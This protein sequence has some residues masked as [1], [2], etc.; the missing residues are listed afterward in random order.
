MDRTLY[1]NEKRGLEVTRDGPS[2][3]VR[4]DGLAGKRIPARLIGHV[5]IVGNVKL[6]AGVITLFTDN[7]VPVTF[8]NKK[9]DEIALTIPYNHQYN[10]HYHDQRQI[11][12]RET[13]I[14]YYKQWLASERRKIQLKVVK[15]LSRSVASVFIK[16]GFK[17]QDYQDFIIRNIKIGDKKKKNM[18]ANVIGNLTREMI[19]AGIFSAGFDPHIGIINRRENFGMVMDIFY[20]I[21]PE[22][23]L[24]TIQ[25]F[26]S[27]SDK[28][29][30]YMSSTGLAISKDGM[31]D[32]AQRF[33]NKKRLVNEFIENILD[34]LFETIRN[35]KILRQH[36]CREV[37]T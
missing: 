19:L 15:K 25:F 1:I 10:A 23:D 18:V 24:Q 14:N 12:E 3:W 36:R 33:E 26:Q 16:H 20:A 2:I 27:A 35:I 11:L 34:G 13:S 17:E 8:M 9:G 31:R 28:D 29:Y 30:I 32:I 22:A 5:V 6:D 4:E 7:N 21:E 37:I